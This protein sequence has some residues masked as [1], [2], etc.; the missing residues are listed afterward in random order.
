MIPPRPCPGW[1]S[2]ARVIASAAATA[3]SLPVVYRAG[4]GF[5]L[6][7][8]DDAAAHGEHLSVDEGVG[9]HTPGGRED[10]GE[11]RPGY[12]H[13]FCSLFLVEALDVG[14]AKCLQ[15]VEHQGGLR[16]RFLEGGIGIEGDRW[17]IPTDHSLGDG[18][19]HD[20]IICS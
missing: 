16:G 19:R 7:L 14:E 18:S 1:S 12:T 20:V 6:A 4:P 9:D 13:T 10:A 17:K 8:I 3:T 15:T 5:T 2:L 11:G